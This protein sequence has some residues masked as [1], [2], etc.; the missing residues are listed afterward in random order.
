MLRLELILLAAVVLWV[1][2]GFE[3]ACSVVG[4]VCT[5]FMEGGVLHIAFDEGRLHGL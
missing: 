2:A 1:I 5:I 3:L 4:L